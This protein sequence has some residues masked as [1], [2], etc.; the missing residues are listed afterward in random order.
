MEERDQEMV[1]LFRI[2]LCLCC[3][4]LA[5]GSLQ[6]KTLKVKNRERDNSNI[7]KEFWVGYPGLM[8]PERY[9]AGARLN[10]PVAQW[11]FPASPSHRSSLIYTKG[12]A[13][14]TV[15]PEE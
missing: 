9:W 15:D 7:A 3:T 12:C 13:S 14:E 8:D 5:Q 11:N 1:S 10:F 2:F 4:E 6:N